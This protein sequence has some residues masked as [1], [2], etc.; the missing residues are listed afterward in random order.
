MSVGVA[1]GGRADLL[2]LA[3]A[4]GAARFDPGTKDGG[5]EEGGQKRQD[6]HDHQS[7]DQRGSLSGRSLPPW[8]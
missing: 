8:K 5:Y 3:E 4:S 2:E 7:F 1:M 6:A